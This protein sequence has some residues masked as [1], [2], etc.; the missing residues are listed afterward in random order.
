MAF[1]DGT[2]RTRVEPPSAGEAGLAA[3]LLRARLVQPHDMLQALVVQRQGSARLTDVLLRHRMAAGDALYGLLAAREGIEPA[4]LQV[5]PP[6]PRL[7]DRLGCPACLRL[8]V[9]PW[10]KSGGVTLVAAADA[11]DFHHARAELEARLGPVA[12]ALAPAGQISAALLSLRGRQ[13]D[14]SARLT[15]PA[16][17]SC[18]GWGSERQIHIALALLV[19]LVIWALFSAGT[20]LLALT[21]WALFTLLVA[22]VM[23]AAA[24][25]AMLRP[26]VPSPP[27]SAQP[28]PLPRLPVVSVMV[29]LYREADIAPRLVRRLGLLDYP[30]DLLDILLVVEEEDHLTR[31]ALAL[32]DLP[33]WM[34]IIVVPGGRLKTKPRALNHALG[35][36]RGA[37]V[38]VYDAE[39]APAPDQLRRVVARFQQRGP[40]VA[41]L[42]GVLDFYNPRTNWLSRCFTM[43][44][45][46]WF[47][48]LLP[49]LERIGFPIPLGG[50][51]LFFRRDALQNLGAWDAYNVTE[52]A[53]LG[54][55]LARHG[56][57]TE[58]IDTTT[59]EEANCRALPWVKQRSRWLKGYMM[60]YAVHMR[61]PALLWRQLGWWKFLAFQVFFLTTLSQFLLAPLLWMFW[62]MP[63]GVTLH[64][65]FSL[66][67]A[68]HVI[69]L[70]LFALSE[71][72]QFVMTWAAL[73]K[74]PNRMN[75][76]WGLMLHLYFPLGS[77]ASYKAAWELV[78]KPFYWDKTTHG[79]YDPQ[80]GS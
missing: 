25:A 49:G 65:E 61:D 68:L 21:V 62:V 36:C 23:K 31:N 10:R 45:A 24:F 47:R 16:A 8:A 60:T 9:L 2:A 54:M 39:D 71:V 11:E 69:A 73:R 7:I 43:E 63:F 58:L 79:I 50:T 20:L 35:A 59:F 74:T 46:A 51:T 56:F 80:G 38:G 12:M 13:M 32:A 27:A 72:L 1:A 75:P 18:R 64:P 19:C 77:L 5:Q 33:G 29:A 22:T 66:P 17:E 52:D 26:A 4:D 67:P 55:R 53:D 34:R 70:A 6:D 37:I 41:C 42:Q 48:L 14:R 40:Q 76:L 78:S 3:G 28:V 44:Y 15:V 30:R 57:R